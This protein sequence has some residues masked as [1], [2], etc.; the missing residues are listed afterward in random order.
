MH[1]AGALAV[2]FVFC[3]ILL[4]PCVFSLWVYR[5]RALL[6]ASDDAIAVQRGVPDRLRGRVWMYSSGAYFKM[7]GE[8]DPSKHYHALLR[9]HEREESQATMVHGDKVPSRAFL[10]FSSAVCGCFLVLKFC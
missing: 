8:H 7:L 5:L 10:A 9:A 6:R 1:S 4:V 2:S 3:S